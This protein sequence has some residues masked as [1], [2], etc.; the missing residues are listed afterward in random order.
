MTN[1]PG[2]DLGD[3]IRL[4]LGP[5]EAVLNAMAAIPETPEEVAP[6]SDNEM[7][8]IEKLATDAAALQDFIKEAIGSKSGDLR[9]LKAQL[10]ERLIHFGLKEVTIAGRPPIELNESKTRKPTRKAI[11]SVMQKQLVEELGET[12][13]K[14]E[15]KLRA[16]KL[17]ASIEQSTSQ[18]LSIPDPSPPE[19]ES[20]Y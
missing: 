5:P 9:K 3:I 1:D 8:E 16:F 15:G 18:S 17:W 2:Y 10:K 19:M 7:A 14:K 12:E 4:S 6:P 20:P 11:V 13:A